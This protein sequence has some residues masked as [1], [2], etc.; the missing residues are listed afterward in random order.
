[1]LF[2]SVYSPS[3]E[4]LPLRAR[5]HLYHRLWEVLSGEDTSGEFKS[6][7]AETRVAIREILVQTKKDLPAYWRL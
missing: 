5:R 1:M 4:A 6:L 2:R 7:P 3:F